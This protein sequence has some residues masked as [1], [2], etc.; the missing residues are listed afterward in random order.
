M[1]D[2]GHN[3]R[4]VIFGEI[5]TA[6]TLVQFV[7]ALSDEGCHIEGYGYADELSQEQILDLLSDT[8]KRK[9]KI[10][11]SVHEATEPF[12][13]VSATCDEIGMG[14]VIDADDADHSDFLGFKDVKLPE[15]DEATRYDINQHGE[16]YFTV[17]DVLE[18]KGR[19]TIQKACF[20]KDQ[21]TAADEIGFKVDPEVMDEVR[22][23]MDLTSSLP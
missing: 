13:R 1:S 23:E 11:L 6:E 16:I 20:I 12:G 21:N 18:M 22:Q 19:K 3:A 7:E 5:K 9:D 10:E 14:Y 15:D 8:L 4:M 17:D 2:I